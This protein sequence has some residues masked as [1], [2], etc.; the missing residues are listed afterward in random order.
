[1][2]EGIAPKIRRITRP[3]VVRWFRCR[4]VGCKQYLKAY[5]Q[6]MRAEEVW[7]GAFCGKCKSRMEV[8]SHYRK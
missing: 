3:W 1:M 4:R 6:R 7:G 2:S 8:Y 5:K